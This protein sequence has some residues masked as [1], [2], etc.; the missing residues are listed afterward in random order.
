[1]K[2]ATEGQDVNAVTHGSGINEAVQ[3]F[4]FRPADMESLR[5]REIERRLSDTGF[6]FAELKRKRMKDYGQQTRRHD[7]A[8][9]SS[10]VGEAPHFAKQSSD[11]DTAKAIFVKRN[12]TEDTAGVIDFATHSTRTTETVYEKLQRRRSDPGF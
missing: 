5:H 11:Q 10:S 4:R 3:K 2:E 1:L 8:K 7:P 12:S 9:R 6:L